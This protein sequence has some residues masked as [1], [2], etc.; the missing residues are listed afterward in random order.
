MKLTILGN[1]P[2]QKNGKSV[3]VNPRT[4]RI[5]VTSNPRVKAW[6]DEALWQLKAVTPYS[7]DYPTR[8]HLLFSFS[9]NRRRDLDNAC[10][11]VFD[12]LRKAD[13]IADDDYRHLCP[14]TL[15][16][17]GVDKANPRVEISIG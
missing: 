12:I 9:D 14:I 3:G 2:S 17:A 15:D 4:H 8:I 11:S 16:C 6:Q 5:F 10:A 7:G 13:I 1:V